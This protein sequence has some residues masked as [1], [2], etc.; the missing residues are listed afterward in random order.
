MP[1]RPEFPTPYSSF[2]GHE[3]RFACILNY[4]FIITKNMFYDRNAHRSTFMSP[5]RAHI[6][7][8]FNLENG[9]II[10][11]GITRKVRILPYAEKQAPPDTVGGIR[12]MCS[13]ANAPNLAR[14]HQVQ[15]HGERRH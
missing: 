12:L 13:P 11:E 7:E 14:A 2:K 10:D 8:I 3:L 5:D 15:I 9:S 6:L 1:F 4:H